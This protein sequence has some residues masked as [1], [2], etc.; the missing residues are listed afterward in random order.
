MLFQWLKYISYK[1]FCDLS[2]LKPLSNSCFKCGLCVCNNMRDSKEDECNAAWQDIQKPVI[3]CHNHS[4]QIEGRLPGA[5][6][7]SFLLTYRL[8]GNEKG[9][10]SSYPTFLSNRYSFQQTFLLYFCQLINL[11]YQKLVSW[12]TFPLT[13]SN[14]SISYHKTMGRSSTVCNCQ[15]STLRKLFE[16]MYEMQPSLSIHIY[17]YLFTY[18]Y[19]PI[20][21]SVYM[22]GQERPHAIDI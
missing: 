10:V 14:F 11:Y 8:P 2:F 18:I 4:I 1:I 5:F 9:E 22:L 21:V 3:V 19:I 17:V 6:W 16:S 20:Y 7:G 12:T 13:V 15:I